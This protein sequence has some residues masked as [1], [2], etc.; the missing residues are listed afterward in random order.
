VYGLRQ[1]RDHAGEILQHPPASSPDTPAHPHD[2]DTEYGINN[3]HPHRQLEVYD[4]EHGDEKEQPQRMQDR[5]AERLCHGFVDLGDI[6]DN[7]RYDG[8]G[9]VPVIIAHRKHQDMAVEEI[10]HILHHPEVEA[11]NDKLVDIQHDIFYGKRNF[12]G[13]ISLLAIIIH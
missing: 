6:I 2:N 5:V 10:S 12:T 4:K 13:I 1:N 7:V 9:A 3:K 11:Q 8:A